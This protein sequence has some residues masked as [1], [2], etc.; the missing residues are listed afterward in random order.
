MHNQGFGTWKSTQLTE[1]FR[2]SQAK[3]LSLAEVADAMK[4]EGTVGVHVVGPVQDSAALQALET[5]VIVH[6]HVLAIEQRAGG[7]AWWLGL[8]SE[9][10]VWLCYEPVGTLSGYCLPLFRPL[11][12]G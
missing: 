9:D 11:M 7:F 6:V 10:D 12:F 3:G 5:E 1:R 2:R 4:G 8:D